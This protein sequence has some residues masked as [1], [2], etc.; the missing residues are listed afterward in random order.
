LTESK[1]FAPGYGEFFTGDQT[2]IEALALGLPADALPGA[3]PADVL[4]LTSGAGSVEDAVVATN[5]NTAST[6]VDAMNTA[7][8]SYRTGGVPPLLETQMNDALTALTQAVTARNAIDAR[9]AAVQVARASLDF[10]LRHR[11]HTEIDMARFDLWALQ[12][13]V[14][15]DA[16]AAGDTLAAG[17]VMGDVTSMEWVWKRFSHTL[18]SA[19]SSSLQAILAD[20]RTAADASNLT[21]ARTSAEQLRSALAG[22]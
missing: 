11:P 20:L 21:A 8:A 5:W 13:L 10:E 7:W 19:T 15:A 17:N 4:T 18:D 6:T 9:M 16:G 2:D 22:L 3:P 1:T 14:D 12:I